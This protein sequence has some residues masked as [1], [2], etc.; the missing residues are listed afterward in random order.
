MRFLDSL[1]KIKMYFLGGGRRVKRKLKAIF[2]IFFAV[3]LNRCDEKDFEHVLCG[4]EHEK[5]KL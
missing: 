1:D 2:H 3:Y 4:Q 5:E